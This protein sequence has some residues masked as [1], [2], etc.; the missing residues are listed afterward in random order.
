M[1]P[2]FSAL[3]RALPSEKNR[4]SASVS[5]ALSPQKS[6]LR[7]SARLAPWF[8]LPYLNGPVPM[9]FVL[10]VFADAADTMHAEPAAMWKS[11]LSLYWFSVT[12]TV[13]SSTTSTD[14]TGAQ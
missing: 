11:Q 6:G 10:L 5:F 8:Q 4:N 9:G 12:L 2:A 14:L 7:V 13:P 3:F 1:S